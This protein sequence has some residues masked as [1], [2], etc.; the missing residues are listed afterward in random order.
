MLLMRTKKHVCGQQTSALTEKYTTH[1]GMQ[2]LEIFTVYTVSG[3]NSK[4]THNMYP[5]SKF[6]FSEMVK[7]INASIET[8]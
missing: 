7:K 6:F 1:G 2:T 4:T 8:S 5:V 3:F